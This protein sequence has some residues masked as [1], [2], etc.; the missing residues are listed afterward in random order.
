MKHDKKNHNQGKRARRQKDTTTPN[1]PLALSDDT[2]AGS[3]DCTTLRPES[4]AARAVF[5][6]VSLR[7]RSFYA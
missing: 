7:N 6:I 5:N 1:N 3:T 2:R 4:H